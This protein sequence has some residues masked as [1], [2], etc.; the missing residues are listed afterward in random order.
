MSNTRRGF[1]LEDLRSQPWLGDEDLDAFVHDVKDAY[2][3]QIDPETES[4][5]IRLIVDEVRVVW[6]PSEARASWLRASWLRASWQSRRLRLAFQLATVMAL[7]TVFAGGLAV[8]ATGPNENANENALAAVAG[9]G[10]PI[11]TGARAGFVGT[12]LDY[13]T[14]STA[15]GCDFGQGVATIASQGQGGNAAACSQSDDG[16]VTAGEDTPK[17][18]RATGEAHSAGRA[19]GTGA[20]GGPTTQGGTATA[21]ERSGGRLGGRSDED[22]AS[23]AGDHASDSG[24]GDGA[25][26]SRAR[27]EEHSQGAGGKPTEDP[28]ADVR[29]GPPADL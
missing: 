17:G 11:S 4:R 14:N 29:K 19:G 2:I 16:A 27:G 22:H 21:E 9:A 13:I 26:G 28:A 7:G 25:Q 8:A 15:E 1:T 20:Q 5:H 3:V 18:S 10:E 12:L 6:S 23:T 24:Q